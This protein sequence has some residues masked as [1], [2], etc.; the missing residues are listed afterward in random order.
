MEY[1][2]Y[3]IQLKIAGDIGI[4]RRLKQIGMNVECQTKAED[5]KELPQE[6]YCDESGFTGNDLLNKSQPYF[7]YASIAI[8]NEEAKA[9]VKQLISDFNIQGG[10]LKGQR[11]LKYNKGKK[12][13]T[14][15]L[16]N[17]HNKIQVSVFHKT[18]NLACKFFEYIF[19]PVIQKN[20]LLFYKIGFHKFI[21][22]ILYLELKA[23]SQYAEDIFDEFE[24]FIRRFDISELRFL[25]SSIV[26]PNI[27]PILDDIKSF[28]LYNQRA[29]IEEIDSLRSYG[30][31]KWALDLTD[32]ALFN[33]L[34]EWGLR[35]DQ[36]DVY[37]DKSDPLEHKKE[38]F[39][40]MINREEK[41]YNTLL[42][43]TRPLTFNLVREIQF[44][45]SKSF[46]GIQIAD[47]IAATFAYI[48]GGGNDDYINEWRKYLPYSLSPI[49]VLPEI[50]KVDLNTLSAKINV[51]LLKEVV[52]RSKKFMPILDGLPEFIEHTTNYLIEEISPSLLK[53]QNCYHRR[54]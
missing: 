30:V 40:V 50:D 29:I 11:L 10:E 44:V 54:Q 34:A 1:K 27:S 5:M 42:D 21:S 13:I 53:I 19:E 26:L 49:S 9:F 4:T 41:L 14:K 24:K 46:P 39:M 6:I 18:Y 35:F 8:R 2:W 23:R 45:D 38:M 43:K 37:C 36:L 17:Y 31:G 51:L 15:I 32:T 33:Q 25:S 22:N 16:E 52:F 28:Y 48:F 7:T 20:N 3:K 47:T 12:T